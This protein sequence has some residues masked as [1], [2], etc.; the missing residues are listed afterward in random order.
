MIR[1]YK[2]I[3]AVSGPLVLISQVEG[4]V[5]GELAEVHLPDGSISRC[6]VLEIN[7]DTVLAE[8]FGSSSG[9]DV[10]NTKIRFLG[11][12]FE[13][14]IS[15][16]VLGRVFNSM[17][18]PVDG[19]P[20]ILPDV[21]RSI[22][23]LPT[24]PA[25]REFPNK[26]IDT[27]FSA[28]DGSNTLIRGQ[29]LAIFSGAGLP[30]AELAAHIARSAASG[31]PQA[32]YAIVFASIGLSF[33]ETEYVIQEFR[34]TELIDH[35]V[36]FTCKAGS[37][38]LE[39]F[40]A[41]RT[42]LTTAEYLAFDKDMHVFV[43]LSDMMCYAEALRE[44]SSAKNMPSFE[45][46]YPRYLH[47]D[48]GEICERAGLR[49]GK[50]GSITILPVITMP[51]DQITHSAADALGHTCEGQIVLSRE[52]HTRGIYPPVDL[53]ASRSRLGDVI[54]GNEHR[55][56]MIRLL[57]SYASGKKFHNLITAFGTDTVDDYG[58]KLTD[59]FVR[60]EKKYICQNSDIVRSAGE[61]ALIAKELLRGLDQPD[62]E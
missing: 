2:T 50:K 17:G 27:G 22:N 31:D 61:T 5:C 28:I 37:P 15:T 16:D 40:A 59:F 54:S 55:A 8:L 18:E 23:G 6:R 56:L 46:G 30:H 11:R 52:L 57:S 25:A 41:P 32:E 36:T 43:I 49:A 34:R 4:A 3:Q 7:G 14:G 47:R 13:L 33:E 29:K 45:S 39:R 48:F 35:T 58:K 9:M 51:G 38:A 53:L 21:R 12:V 62:E 24:N 26:A 1:E 19:G 44:L 60:L 42:A 10:D 20:K